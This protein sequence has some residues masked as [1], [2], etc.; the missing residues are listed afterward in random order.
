MTGIHLH[1][2]PEFVFLQGP[3]A[4]LSFRQE[5]GWPKA[6]CLS[7]LGSCWVFPWGTERG[8]EGGGSS[9]EGTLKGGWDGQTR[10]GVPWLRTTNAL[11]E[12]PQA[13]AGARADEAIISGN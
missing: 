7:A 13:S 5:K 6:P 3:L 8:G 4:G 11:P 10:E 9:Q 1:Q 12:T 2:V